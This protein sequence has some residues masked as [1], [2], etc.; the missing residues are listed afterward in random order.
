MRVIVHGGAGSHPADP[1][2][3]G[4]TLSSA[5]ETGAA[6]STPAEAVCAAIGVLEADPEFNAGIGSARQ[7]DGY[8]RT[9]AGIMS[10]DRS[11]GAVCSMPGVESAVDVARVVQ[12][13]TPHVLV[14]GVHA[15]DLAA[16]AGIQTGVDL[17]TSETDDRWAAADPPDGGIETQLAWV[18]ERFGADDSEAGDHD[19]V[20]AVATDGDRL[21]AATS[22]GG[23]WFALAGRVGDV[24][25]VGSGFYCNEF[26]G[27]SA[28]G[29]GE[30]IARETLSRR[31]VDR[32]ADGQSPQAAAEAAIEAFGD[33]TDGHAG[34]ICLTPDGT[35]GAD[36]NSRS[37]QTAV[38]GSV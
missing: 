23:R 25:Q 29:A 21:T 17:S 16:A 19:T 27:A 34:V 5:A 1:K 9:D 28:T 6:E 33:R 30:D 24:P 18:D 36:Y 35:V 3:R 8:A 38:A 2:S 31:V 15:V 22:T 13:E 20:G 26:G 11:I 4:E 14:S 12:T 32:L 10:E 7:A 37:M